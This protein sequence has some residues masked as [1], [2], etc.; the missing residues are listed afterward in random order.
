MSGSRPPSRLQSL[1]ARIVKTVLA[2]TPLRRVVFHRYDYMFRPGDLAFLVG[3]LDATK[4]LDGG[5]VEI[6]CAGGHT[7]VFLC[8][9]LDDQHDDREYHAIDT[10]GGFTAADVDVERRRGKDERQYRTVFRAY[11]KDW[12]ERTV[13]DN[14]ISRV[15]THEADINEFDV[16]TIGALSMCLIDVDL[17]RPVTAALEKVAPALVPG[18]MVIVDDCLPSNE[19]DGALQAYCEFVDARGVPREFH[20][21][22]GIIRF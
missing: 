8:K 3:C 21:K 11:R 9:H 1:T 12:Y 6:G 14:G 22:L 17:Y 5:V 18:G 19:Y 16:S 7:T 4:G 13:R 10:F 15:L 20:G 2:R